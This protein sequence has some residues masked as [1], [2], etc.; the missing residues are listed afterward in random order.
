MIPPQ[1]PLHERARRSVHALAVHSLFHTADALGALPMPGDAEAPEIEVLRDIAYLPGG[2]PAH[3]LDLYRPV[4][5]EGAPALLYI[6]GGGFRTLSR[7][8]HWMMAQAFARLGYAVFTIDY[9][10]GPQHPFPTPLKDASAALLWIDA[11]AEAYGADASAIVLAGESA[12]ANLALSLGMLCAVARPEPWAREVFERGIRPGA[13]VAASGLLDV[14][15]PERLRAHPLGRLGLP[16]ARDACTTYLP[17]PQAPGALLASPLLWLE[18]L[19][20]LD[21]PLAPVCAPFG[22]QDPLVL[23]APRLTSALE[24]LGVAHEAP[25]YPGGGH[26]FM[27]FLWTARAQQCWQDMRAFLNRAGASQTPDETTQAA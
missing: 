2:D 17:D 25:V 7:R 12:G 14:T 19:D 8:T 16:A 15:A 11:R 22:A 9:R 10:M 6:H 23:D 20:A 18:R 13:I 24:R 1:L 4:G 5:S 3:R 27:A 26:S 21:R